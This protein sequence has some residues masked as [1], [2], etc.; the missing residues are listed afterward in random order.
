MFNESGLHAESQPHA[1]SAAPCKSIINLSSNFSSDPW[2][3]PSIRV[4]ILCKFH[5][6][7]SCYNTKTIIW[8]MTKKAV[9]WIAKSYWKI[10]W[11]Q[12]C[13]KTD[14]VA[15]LRVVG[16]LKQHWSWYYP[17][18]FS[19]RNA[20][21]VFLWSILIDGVW[22][23]F[24]VIKLVGNTHYFPTFYYYFYRKCNYL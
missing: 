13:Y 19:S 5:H 2:F 10:L 23:L 24:E 14:W 18:D 8:C 12:Q 21:E 1:L 7:Y 9:Y 4:L 20:Q 16:Y 17:Q 6:L 11:G 15:W 22:F 3:S